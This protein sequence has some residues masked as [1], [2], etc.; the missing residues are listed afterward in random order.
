MIKDKLYNAE[1]YY[2]LS[3]NLKIG[4]E[5][6]KNTNLEKIEDGKYLIEGEQV[7]ANVQTYETKS[8]APYE[9]HRNYI[10]I[11]YMVN[12][13]EKIGVVDY[14]NCVTEEAYDEKRD[15]E[16][17]DFEGEDEYC[18]LKE[19]EFVVLYPNDAHKPSIDLGGKRVVKKVVVKVSI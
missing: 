18:S 7:Y 4:F 14:K 9:S 15:I 6:L 2:R 1:N 5:W 8:T 19:G 12:G 13:A 11:Q 10:D 3:D 16:F 17:L